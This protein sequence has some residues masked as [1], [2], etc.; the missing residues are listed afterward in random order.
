MKKKLTTLILMLSIFGNITN[1]YAA[2]FTNTGEGTSDNWG[3][4][5]T[6]PDIAGGLHVYRA[7]YYSRVTT[8]QTFTINAYNIDGDSVMPSSTIINRDLYSFKAGTWVGINAAELYNINWEIKLD[9]ESIIYQEKV[10]NYSCVY[11]KTINNIW[12]YWIPV[13]NS[14]ASQPYN[15][16][17]PASY[18][19]SAENKACSCGYNA[20]GSIPVTVLTEY[21]GLNTLPAYNETNLAAS[22]YCNPPELVG[23]SGTGWTLEPTLQENHGSVWVNPNQVAGGAAALESK[24]EQIKNEMKRITKQEA[25]SVS[26]SPSGKMEYIASNT[27]PKTPRDWEE[28]T[29]TLE[30][31]ENTD[32]SITTEHDS[33][34]TI[35]KLYEFLQPYVCINIKTA[36]VTYGRTCNDKEFQI[37]NRKVY[38]SNL[39][40]NVNY[41]HYF[42]PLDTKTNNEFSLKIKN[43]GETKSKNWCKQT[44]DQNPDYMNYIVPLNNDSSFGR[45]TKEEDK[46][47]IENSGGCKVEI[48]IKFPIEQKFYNE[49][50][51]SG[52]I[53][54]KGFNFYYK[55][56]DI[57]NPFPNGIVSESL[58]EGWTGNNPTISD[59][60]DDITYQ[61][62]IKDANQ[63]R[64]YNTEDNPYTSWENM[65][66]NGRSKFIEDEEFMR[67]NSSVSFYKLGCGPANA[68]PSSSIYIEG[69][70]NKS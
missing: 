3:A 27:F 28:A 6:T 50:E 46:I 64:R 5:K 70:E 29:K 60:Y 13:G 21:R 55:P 24:K 52:N 17:E 58:W 19:P 33:G 69:C 51:E 18:D 61:A 48:N 37:K 66:I 63:I 36:E 34:G 32:V 15:C 7:T 40:E 22:S 31:I 45:R 30:P 67:R 14:C 10:K 57:N 11:K 16:K 39:R 8:T 41:W 44:I 43:M 65:Y 35:T 25:Q 59:S 47:I 23:L 62:Y 4:A 26:V 9:D 42:I 54:F 68:N 38:D 2:G 49:V 53:I 56:I 1:C 12:Y 20:D